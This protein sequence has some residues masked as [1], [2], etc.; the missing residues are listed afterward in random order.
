MSMSRTSPANA[1]ALAIAAAWAAAWVVTLASAPCAAAEG[2]DPT[3]RTRA[4]AS[5]SAGAGAS[6]AADV[7]D[8]APG[9]QD[10]MEGPHSGFKF[11]VTPGMAFEPATS[12]AGFNLGM[13][14]TYGIE[15]G[16]IVVAPGL[17]AQI[18]V[19]LGTRVLMGFPELEI[20]V[21]I[22]AFAPFVLV[23]AGLGA[24]STTGRAGLAIRGAA[25]VLW[26]IS[27]AFGI[28]ADGAYH[29]VTGFTIASIELGPVVSF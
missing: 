21:P 4:G 5:A 27:D 13:E 3:A 26:G 19:P 10:P 2:D 28:V 17:A 9:S 24:D 8:S 6:G 14:G 7:H 11:A 23:G 1:S 20:L 25:G 18:L 22:G 29:D 12:R 16:P 15:L